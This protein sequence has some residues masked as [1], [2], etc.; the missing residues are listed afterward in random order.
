MVPLSTL[1]LLE[2]LKVFTSI[3]DFGLALKH[4]IAEWTRL[5]RVINLFAIPFFFLAMMKLEITAK[6]Y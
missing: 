6:Y 2:I 1:F 4:A 5:S 3:A